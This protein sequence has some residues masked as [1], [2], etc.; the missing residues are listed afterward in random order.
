MPNS[1]SKPLPSKYE[2]A[3]PQTHDAF[4]LSAPKIPP[5][6]MIKTSP[7]DLAQKEGVQK[8]VTDRPKKTAYDWIDSKNDTLKVK[9]KDKDKFEA[10]DERS[11]GPAGTAG[12]NGSMYIRATTSFREI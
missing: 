4:D 8:T 1:P 10:P 9:D 12:V 5:A 2:I 11:G 3:V 7:I 6:R